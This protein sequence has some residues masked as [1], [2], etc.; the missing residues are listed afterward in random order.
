MTKRAKVCKV[1][2]W[3]QVKVSFYSIYLSQ[4]D[5]KFVENGR[6]VFSPMQ[7]AMSSNLSDPKNIS[8]FPSTWHT[9]MG[10][11][12]AWQGFR[13]RD[14]CYSWWFVCFSLCKIYKRSWRTTDP[15]I[16]C[17]LCCAFKLLFDLRWGGHGQQFFYLTF[18]QSC[19]HCCL[20]K[21][22][23]SQN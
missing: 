10:K 6:I 23:K 14:L 20:Q 2:H 18:R 15:I 8:G 22:K 12:K 19:F 3:L 21:H 7:W 16:K 11:P 5:S 9:I 17:C 13:R 1:F 4:F